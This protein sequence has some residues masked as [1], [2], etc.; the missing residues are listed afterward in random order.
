MVDRKHSLETRRTMVEE[1]IKGKQLKTEKQ[2]Y[3]QGIL[4]YFIKYP[5]RI[6]LRIIE[7]NIRP[8][9]QLRYKV[10]QQFIQH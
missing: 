9:Y 4:R 5:L 3:L 1:T 7:S 10:S 2:S 6:K 8:I